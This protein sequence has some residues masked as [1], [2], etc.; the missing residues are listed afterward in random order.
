MIAADEVR[1]KLLL[2]WARGIAQASGKAIKLVKLSHREDIMEISPDGGS[3][4]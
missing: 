1:L 4:Q 2:P 3:M